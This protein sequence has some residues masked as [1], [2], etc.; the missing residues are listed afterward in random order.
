MIE[1][2][3]ILR[4]Y[5]TDDQVDRVAELLKPYMKEEWRPIETAPKNGAPILLFA[6]SKR[7][8]APGII[9]GWHLHNT[10][11]IEA[12]FSPNNPVG[13]VPTYWQSLPDFP[14]GAA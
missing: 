8:V 12:T 2:S 3:A 7:A 4:K 10:E 1:V 14:I 5:L 13:I 9:I 6:R 11:W